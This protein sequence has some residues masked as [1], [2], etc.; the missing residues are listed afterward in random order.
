M[1]T[2][3]GTLVKGIGA[4]AGTAAGP[5]FLASE[6]QSPT[7]AVTDFATAAEGVARRLE[8]LARHSAT[9][10]AAG[11]AILES[12]AAMARDPALAAAVREEEAAGKSLRESVRAAAE[13]YARRLE[14]LD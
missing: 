7:G 6:A 1:I 4:S 9:Q 2:A 12:Q 13:R 11:A 3:T 5:V 8:K 14:A 10:H